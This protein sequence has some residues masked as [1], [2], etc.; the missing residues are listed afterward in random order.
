MP[1]HTQNEGRRPFSLLIKPASADCNL[2]CS[3]CFYKGKSALYPEQSTHRMSAST[4]EH[5]VRSYMET[6]QPQY[7]FSWQG[8]EP[9]LMGHDFFERVT[10][11]QMKWGRPGAS[12]ANAVQTNGTLVTDRLAR[13]F[14][15][16][17]FLLGVSLDGP[18]EVHDRYRIARDGSGT[19]AQ[20]VEGLRTLQ[21]HGVKTNVLTL[22]NAFNAA[23]PRE[24]YRYLVGL[25]ILH[26]QYIPC[27][28]HDWNGC[29]EPYSL[30]P[31]RWGNFLCAMFD[32][33]Y[34]ADVGRVS[35]R[36]FDSLL[37]F[38]ATGQYNACH[39]DRSCGSYLLV[40][41]NG[42]VYP[43]DFFVGPQWKIGNVLDDGWDDLIGRPEYR[44][45]SAS[46]SQWNSECDACPHLGICSADCLKFRHPG[47]AGTDKSLLCA[48]Y[49]QFFDHA[50]DTLK[51]VAG[52]LQA[53]PAAAGAEAPRRKQPCPCGSGRK[54]RR[55]C[56]SEA[57]P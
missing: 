16:F 1:D 8:G 2:D 24:L 38:L 48:G 3:Y 17:N 14:R 11:L 54:Y 44:S 42:D 18:A 32:C 41:H 7:G 34:P 35:V 53:R 57:A 19:H 25:G 27:V 9:L 36:Y 23:R 43:C 31:E 47:R 52:A 45:F 49:R 33:W 6:G 4:L 12:V 15:K 26:H 10:D 30:S 39:M 46:K 51:A 40:E 21:R 50:L 5:I 56:G 22:V 29:P 37:S 28:E 55:C 20:V 13:H